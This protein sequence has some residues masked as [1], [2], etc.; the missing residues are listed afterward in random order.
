VASAD[1]Q[2]MD[3]PMISDKP[4]WQTEYFQDMYARH[5]GQKRLRDRVRDPL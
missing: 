4:D 1:E 2:V 3:H 5:A